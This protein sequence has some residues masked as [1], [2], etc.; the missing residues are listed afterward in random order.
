MDLTMRFL[1][2]KGVFKT[3]LQF[4]FRCLSHEFNKLSWSDPKVNEIWS[5][6]KV[7]SKYALRKWRKLV[8]LEPEGSRLHSSKNAEC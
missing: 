6:P 7:S 8:P 2:T 4:F 3:E 1:T 5:G